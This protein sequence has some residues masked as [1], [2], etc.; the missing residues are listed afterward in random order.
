MRLVSVVELDQFTY[1]LSVREC[2]TD[3]RWW[4]RNVEREEQKHFTLDVRAGHWFDA[5]R[6]VTDTARSLRLYELLLA[7]RSELALDAYVGIDAPVHVL[8]PVPVAPQ[9]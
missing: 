6:R 9:R 1:Q 5:D 3:R 2:W 7:S 4:W 8:P